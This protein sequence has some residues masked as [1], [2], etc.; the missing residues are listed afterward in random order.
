MPSLKDKVIDAIIEVEGGYSNRADDAGGETMYGVTVAVARAAGYEGP[1]V[2]MPREFAVKVYAARYWD[3]VRGDDLALL[4]ESLAEEVVDTSVNCGPG[5]AGEFL[6]RA[7]NVLN[8]EGSI[9]SDIAVDGAIGPATVAAARAYLVHRDA[10][11][12]VKA[13]NC[14][15]GAFYI[16]L[17]EARQSDETNLYGWL[18]HRVKL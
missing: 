4:S 5:R 9:Y 16:S 12:L 18:V 2:D 14:L 8:R 10:S 11:V 1:M 6:Q 15:Q 17:A 7:L 13:L 3:V